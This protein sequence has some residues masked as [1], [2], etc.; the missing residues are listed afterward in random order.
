MWVG[1]VGR[2]AYYGDDTLSSG[3]GRA[4]TGTT[5]TISQA[6]PRV[7]QISGAVT[8]SGS[9]LAGVGISGQISAQDTGL[10]LP[11][12]CAY[13][14][15]IDGTINLYEYVASDSTY[16]TRGLPAGSY[17]IQ[18]YSY[19]QAAYLSEYYNN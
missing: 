9:P 12:A 10:P 8:A 14:S 2:R 6:L 1:G 4:S 19:D 15:K 16:R 11:R 7:A 5:Q 18:F 3:C 13:I 17:R